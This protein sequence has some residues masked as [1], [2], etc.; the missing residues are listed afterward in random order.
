VFIDQVLA[1][2]L[3]QNQGWGIEIVNFVVPLQKY[4]PN[5]GI[6]TSRNC[7]CPGFNS[8]TLTALDSMI[9]TTERLAAAVNADV[10]DAVRISLSM[11]CPELV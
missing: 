9:D 6:M 10:A 5:L 3:P 7:F 2:L 1:C 11:S 8:K 4:V